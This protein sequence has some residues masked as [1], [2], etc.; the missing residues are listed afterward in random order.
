MNQDNGSDFQIHCSQTWIFLLKSLKFDGR[1][2]V[3]INYKG[4]R[5]EEAKLSVQT[6]IGFYLLFR[7]V[8]FAEISRPATHLLLKA[9]DGGSQVFGRMVFQSRSEVPCRRAI[10]PFQ[11]AQMVCIKDHH[12]SSCAS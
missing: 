9:D 6:P 8:G 2:F 12:F 4:H 5:A 11:N 10:L 7:F 1:I 3:E